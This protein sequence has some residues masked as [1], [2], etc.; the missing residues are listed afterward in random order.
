MTV[1]VQHQP[2]PEVYWKHKLGTLLWLAGPTVATVGLSI[3]VP[4]AVAAEGCFGKPAWLQSHSSAALMILGAIAVFS[5]FLG[6]SLSPTPP[7]VHQAASDMQAVDA[8]MSA[9]SV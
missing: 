2:S 3:Q 8:E 9:P 1:K 5:G 7:V 6:V 4:M